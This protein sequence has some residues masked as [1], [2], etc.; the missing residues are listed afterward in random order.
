MD[1]SEIRNSNPFHAT[2]YMDALSAR[3]STQRY[4]AHSN[5]FQTPTSSSLYSPNPQS[6]RSDVLSVPRRRFRS[7]RLTGT[8]EQPWREKKD[9]RKI[10]DP[11]FFYGGILIGLGIS[12]FICYREWY[13]VPRHEYCLVLEDHF[14]TL[15]PNTWGHEVQVGGFGASSFDWTTTDASNSYV[16]GEGLHI[17]PTLTTE[18]TNI[19]ADEIYSGYT[20]NLTA[21]G[22][23][24]GTPSSSNESLATS[25]CFINSNETFGRIINPIRS[26]RLTT[27]GKYSIKYGRVEVVAKLP[28][29]D[30]IVRQDLIATSSSR[31]LTL[32][33]QWPAIWMMPED[34][35]YGDWPRSGEIDI[36]ESRGNDAE[37]YPTGNNQV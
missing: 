16:D 20:L 5:P 23:C 29:G 28:L 15:D 2:S 24:T 30:W 7:S 27:A 17:M 26:A 36:A 3:V 25:A 34:S 6:A 37:T 13:R 8:Y 31:L 9:R 33:L 4:S 10:W 35:V 19:T 12:G 22:T 18:T 21:D 32:I 11:I 1:Y 14:S